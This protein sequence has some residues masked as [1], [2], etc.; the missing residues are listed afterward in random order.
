MPSKPD[1]TS[2]MFPGGFLTNAWHTLRMPSMTYSMLTLLVVGGVGGVMFWGGFN[3]AME[4]TNTMPFCISC[5]EMRDN[6]YKEYDK[7]IHHSNRT[8]VQATCSDCHVPKEWVHKFVRKIQASNELW[9]KAM[10]SIDTPEKFAAH[11]LD[12]AKSVWR[13]MKTTDSRE[14]RNCHK[15]DHMEY[16]TQEPRASKLHQTAFAQGK[17][18]IDFRRRRRKP[19]ATCWIT[20]TRS[21]RCRSWSTSCKTRTS[22]V[23]R[24]RDSRR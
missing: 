17:T 22:L 8:G 24:R 10:G 16:A 12:L 5:H 20:S 15:F 3:W 19:T 6:V 23:P 4:S 14:C 13:A 2:R 1:R 21:D 7:T 11:R 9:H 18:C